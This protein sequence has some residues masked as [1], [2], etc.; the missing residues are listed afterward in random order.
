MLLRFV[1]S[2]KVCVNGGE[3]TMQY[4]K[5]HPG[6]VLLECPNGTF[7]LTIDMKRERF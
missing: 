6:D 7:I 5:I 1:H 3:P 4:W 2:A